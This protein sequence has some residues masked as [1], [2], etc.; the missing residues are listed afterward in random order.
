MRKRQKDAILISFFKE[1][2]KYEKLAEYIVSLIG[3]DPSAPK[4]SLHTIKYRIKDKI[5]LIEKIDEENKKPENKTAVITQKN[6]QKKIEDLLGIRLICLRL[7]DIDRV[8]TYLELLAD[9][10]ILRFIREPDHKRSFILPVDP[11]KTIPEGLDLRYSG[12]SSIHYQVELGENS[13]ADDELK[14]LQIEFQLRTILEEAWGEIDH[15]YRYVF[16]RRGD[17]LPEY[18]H[19]GFYSLSAYLQAAALQAE[20]ICRQAEAHR[21]AKTRK[22]KSK[23]VQV[24]VQET[25]TPAFPVLLKKTF[26]FKP[27]VRTLTYLEKRFMESGYTGLPQDIFKKIFTNERLLEF[28]AIFIEVV[29]HEPFE[30]NS[31]KNIDVINAVNFILSIET[32]GKRVAKEGLKSVLIRKKKRSRW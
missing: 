3:D 19:T 22:V 15:K 4:E 6:F 32:Q 30:N 9:E 28:K 16:S 8:K 5:R 26:G 1:K 31:K 20:H 12:Y 21:L 17:D 27:T 11:G 10:K 24:P 18:I 7:S 23:V 25:I 29:N 14:G 2:E 13:G